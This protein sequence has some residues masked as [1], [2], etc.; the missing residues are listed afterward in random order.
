[1]LCQKE[2]MEKLLVSALRLRRTCMTWLE[3][4][5]LLTICMWVFVVVHIV[6]V[7]YY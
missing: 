2:Y 1:M 4:H 6:S 5:I 7:F 3:V